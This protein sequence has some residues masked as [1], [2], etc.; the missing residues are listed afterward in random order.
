MGFMDKVKQQAS[1]LADKAQETAKVG[2]DRLSQLQAKREADAMLVEL[3]RIVYLSRT[4]RT[5]DGAEEKKA[6]LVSRLEAHEADNGPSS[7][8]PDPPDTGSSTT[9]VPS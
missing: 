5:P 9:F 3:G 8:A 4:G 2:Q 7:V 6:E 1:V